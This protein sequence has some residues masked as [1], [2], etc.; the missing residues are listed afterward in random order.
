M[1]GP[2]ETVTAAR[3]EETPCSVV[4]ILRACWRL[5][6]TAGEWRLTRILRGSKISAR[7]R[8]VEQGWGWEVTVTPVRGYYGAAPRE[9]ESDFAPCFMDALAAAEDYALRAAA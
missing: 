3:L 2:A 4:S 9:P 5:D 1:L 8:A 6:P 7:V